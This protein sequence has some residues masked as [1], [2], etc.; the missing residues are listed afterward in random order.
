MV[1]MRMGSMWSGVKLPQG[2]RGGDEEKIDPR[3]PTPGLFMARL[4]P[5]DTKKLTLGVLVLMARAFFAPVALT[6]VE[7]KNIIKKV[8]YSV[9]A[10][11]TVKG[12][13]TLLLPLWTAWSFKCLPGD[14]VYLSV[15]DL[16]K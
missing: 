10:N 6:Q 2:I 5:H 15:F 3:A 12:R 11:N 14:H 8:G 13:M 1:I 16:H 9:A 4:E 7:I